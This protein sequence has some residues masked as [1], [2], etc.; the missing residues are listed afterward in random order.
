M[1]HDLR[2]PSRLPLTPYEAVHST[3]LDEFREA[4]S[5]YLKEHT[6]RLAG[7]DSP[8]MDA[9]L[10]TVRL[11]DTS[12][13]VATYRTGMLV[14]PGPL[15]EFY[16]IHL[17]LAGAT[18]I[19]LGDQ[20]F[21]ATPKLAAV[22]SPTQDLTMQWTPHCAQLICRIERVAFEAHLAETVGHSLRKPLLIEPRMPLADGVGLRVRAMIDAT[23]TEVER[24]ARFI[25]TNPLAVVGFEHMLMSTLLAHPNNYGEAL[26]ADTPPASVRKV[27]D[28][29]AIIASHPELPHTIGSVARQV[30]ASVRS[31]Q[32]GFTVHL[33]TSFQRVLI[34]TRLRRVRDE[35]LAS[36]PGAVSV[37]EIIRRWGFTEDEHFFRLYHRCFGETLAETL[38]E[39]NPRNLARLHVTRDPQGF[40]PT[41]TESQP[42]PPHLHQS[43]DDVPAD[44]TT[45]GQLIRRR[46]RE[47][48]LSQSQLV[49]R[50]TRAIGR[51]LTP[52]RLSEW[53]HDARLIPLDWLPA[54]A[55][56][57]DIPFDQLATTAVL[58]RIR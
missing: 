29:V 8:P 1:H 26:R 36:D 31:V 16:T 4:S 52:A 30:Q 7:R 45:T 58:T 22:V 35:L 47:L 27:R 19:R 11:R 55:A 6:L 5:W 42:R 53:E 57:L 46:R 25:G 18:K 49:A 9:R 3:E 38:R 12:L 28:A 50:L 51:T 37:N 54:L 44:E 33:N 13:N 2:R 21:V 56:E 23:V 40:W 24:S 43:T 39:I 14:R 20:E 32:R 17:P 10:H 34:G 15:R 41:L 48:G